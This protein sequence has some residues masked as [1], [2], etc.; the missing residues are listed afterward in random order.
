[1]KILLVDDDPVVRILVGDYLS[2]HGHQVQTRENG[3]SAME[4]L[5]HKDETP[6][7]VI[8]D[9]MMPDMSGLEVLK[10][11]RST[12]GTLPVVMLSADKSNFNEQTAQ[13]DV[14]LEKPFALDMLE[15]TLEKL[16][17]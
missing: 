13:A 12:N 14:T 9:Y 3:A 6:D 15:A 7:V 10:S 2:A 1:M 5:T 4:A 8:L 17:K 16:L 11:L